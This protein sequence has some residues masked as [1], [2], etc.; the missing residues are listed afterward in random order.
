M[1]KFDAD[2][3]IFG[4][5]AADII[6]GISIADTLISYTNDS[7]VELFGELKGKSIFEVLSDISGSHD[8]GNELLDICRSEGKLTFEGKLAG[9][10]VK[11]HSRIIEYEADGAHP[12]MKC[13][14]AGITDITESFILKKLLYGTSK[15]LKRAAK[16]ADED[17]GNHVERINH[18]SHLLASLNNCETPFIEDISQFA[19]LHDI[20]KINVAD[21]FRLPR[22]LSPG[23][24]NIVKNHAAYGGKMVKGLTGLEMAYNITHEHHEKWDG[25]GYPEGK[26]KEE[27]SLEAR[28]VA[29]AD[30]FDALVSVRPYKKGFSYDRTRQIFEEGDGRV[31]PGHFDPKLLSLFLDNYDKF[32]KIHQTQLQ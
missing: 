9:K 24:M 6:E 29:I 19:Q 1:A 26:Q 16:A 5:F 11:Y 28:I 31:M 15:A 4:V 3:A 12:S 21:I 13:I 25:S 7:C 14:Q 2:F 32:I 27:I 30:V 18:Y 10:I 8:K 20:G 22:K 17:T 23:E